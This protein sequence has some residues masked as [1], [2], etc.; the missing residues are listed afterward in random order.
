MKFLLGPS[1]A[2]PGSRQR[3]LKKRR[4]EA[5][6]LDFGSLAGCTSWANAL[7]TVASVR[8]GGEGREV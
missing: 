1:S 7:K 5:V 6:E 4:K 8:G 2:A 3:E